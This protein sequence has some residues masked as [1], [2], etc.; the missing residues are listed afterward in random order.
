ML[1][2]TKLPSRHMEGAIMRWIDHG[3]PPGSFMHA[4]LTNNLKETL[5]RA[6]SINREQL[7]GLVSWFYNEAPSN[8]WGSEDKVSKWIGL[9]N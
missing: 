9:K 5:A 3:I 4:V 6:D 7:H 2:Y 8:C 1:D